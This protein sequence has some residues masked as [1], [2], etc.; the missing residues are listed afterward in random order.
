MNRNIRTLDVAD[1]AVLGAAGLAAIG[2]GQLKDVGEV[3]SSMVRFGKVYNPIPAN[4]ATYN[5]VAD[6]YKAAY[7]G[8]KSTDVFSKLADI[9]PKA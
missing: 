9:R 3:V 5:K 2:A 8:L 4:V 1:A 6:V 7:D